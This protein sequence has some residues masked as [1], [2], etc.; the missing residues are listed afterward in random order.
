MSPVRTLALALALCPAALATDLHV[1]PLA[2]DD[3]TGTGA[4]GAPFATAGK[5]LSLATAGDTVHLAP[6]HYAPSTGETFPWDLPARVTLQ[7]AGI[8]QTKISGE[9]GHTLIETADQSLVSDLHLERGDVGV[10]SQMKPFDV[11]VVRRCRFQDNAIA[12][13]FRDDLHVDGTLVL[14]NSAVIG[15]DVALRHESPDN[16]FQSVTLLVYGSTITNNADAIHFVGWG[17]RYLGL[18]DSIVRGNLDDSLSDYL[19]TM[20]VTSNLLADP[21]WV[22]TFG[23]LDAPPGI[24]SLADRDPHLAATGAARDHATI[25][26]PWPPAGYW[27]GSGDWI[28]EASYAEVADIDGDPRLVGPFGDAGCDELA[29]PTL[30]LNAPATLGGPV[31]LRLQAEP[32]ASLLAFGGFAT[33]TAPLGG[34]LWIAPPWISL[35]S[36]TMGVSGL[37]GLTVP[38]PA[39]PALAGL[40]L[41]LQA[42]ELTTPLVGS[43][44]EWVRL[45]P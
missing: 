36:A 31:E 25:A 4:A 16:D 11:H 20:G 10:F 13:H 19:V 6:G 37:A 5:A 8:H 29:A 40:D 3:L 7:G 18:Y 22:G 23:N 32:G 45:L 38:I 39:D 1:D 43:G 26:P 33:Y 27:T 28:W 44:P 34:F 17:E 30:H 15:N 12:L 35:G 24:L 14:V 21:A 41:Y 9:G 2:G 42:L